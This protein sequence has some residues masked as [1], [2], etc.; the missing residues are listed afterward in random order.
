MNNGVIP[1]SWAGIVLSLLPVLLVG[2]IFQKWSGR[3]SLTGY[4]TVRMVGQLLLMGYVLIHLF[5]NESGWMG[6]LIVTM[7]L[8][9]SSWIAL[10]PLKQ[11]G[12][13]RYGVIMAALALSGGGM[14]AF[15]L[16]VVVGLEPLYQPRYLI[17]LTGMIFA[18]AMSAISLTGERYDMERTGG[19]PHEL[20]RSVA[21]NAAMIPQINSFFAVGLV[22]LPGMMTGQ[23]LAGVDP[24]FAIR[25]QIVVMAMIFGSAGGAVALYLSWVH[26]TTEPADAADAET[27]RS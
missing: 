12:W 24:A 9:V 23:I 10:R 21:F 3:G 2:W 26:L 6:L 14:L 7:V 16:W 4:A 5:Q 27:A 25:Y 19:K 11:R 18:N 22:S 13:R 17:P 1:I 8:A 15:V 20:A